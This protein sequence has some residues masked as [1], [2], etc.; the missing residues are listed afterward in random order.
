MKLD[1]NLPYYFSGILI[2]LAF[3]FSY[4]VAGNDNL[5]FLLKPTDGI[6][7]LVSGSQSSFGIEQGF[8]H[9]SLHI[10]ID[11]S[12]SGFNFWILC[13]I[14]SLFTSFQYLNTRGWKVASFGICL[15]ASYLLTILVNS[16]RILISVFLLRV[17]PEI[18]T[19][20]S[21]MHEAQGTFIYFS[22][23]VL[24]YFMINRLYSKLPANNE[25]PA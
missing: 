7:S 14:M 16:S 17:D 24:F 11:K 15:V 20:Y 22:F 21:W 2:F 12:C 1:K 18:M 13:F 9:P 5:Y 10:I 4:T 3:K 8:F 19:R 6:V 23:L 25:E